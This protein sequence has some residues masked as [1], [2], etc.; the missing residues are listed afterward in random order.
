MPGYPVK[1]ITCH[2]IKKHYNDQSNDQNDYSYLKVTTIDKKK[3]RTKN[4]YLEMYT[5]DMKFNH[6]MYDI[7]QFNFAVVE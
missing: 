7:V 4:E 5:N 3:Q 2:R 6:N 1:L